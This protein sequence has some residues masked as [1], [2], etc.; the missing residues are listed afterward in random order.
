MYIISHALSQQSYP[1]FPLVLWRHNSL[2]LPCGKS[3]G[4]CL[5]LHIAIILQ[6]RWAQKQLVLF[7]LRGSLFKMPSFAPSSHSGTK[8]PVSF[9]EKNNEAF[10]LSFKPQD[11]FSFFVLPTKDMITNRHIYFLHDA[12]YRPVWCTADSPLRCSHKCRL[13]F[14]TSWVVVQSDNDNSRRSFWLINRWPLTPLWEIL[15]GWCI[16]SRLPWRRAVLRPGRLWA[17]VGRWRSN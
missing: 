16:M 6:Q 10:F 12:E 5:L 17:D 8:H 9:H 15:I 11:D 3:C 13:I 7:R 14:P 4:A 2:I 1:P